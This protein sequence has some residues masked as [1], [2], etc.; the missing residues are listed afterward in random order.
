MVKSTG[1]QFRNYLPNGRIKEVFIMEEQRLRAMKWVDIFSAIILAIGGL[2]WGFI[3]FLEVNLVEK[4][5]GN[6]GMARLIYCIVGLCA[7]Y[8][9][10]MFR[11]IQRRWEC[12]WPWPAKQVGV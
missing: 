12:S 3:G 8:E 1:G 5:F 6:I 7:L 11:T 4:V 10:L 9:I 2:N